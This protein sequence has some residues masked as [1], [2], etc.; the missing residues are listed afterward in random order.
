VT[1]AF[2]AVQLPGAVLDAVVRATSEVW[3]PGRST[4][5]DQWHLTLQFLGDHADV[6]GVIAALDGLDADRGRV[7]IGGAGA[8]PDPRRA[9]VLWLGLAEGADV[10]ARL[11]GAVEA[12]TARLGHARETRPFRPHITLARFAAASDVHGLISEIGDDPI[13]PAWDIDAVSVFESRRDAGGASYI[14]R[15]T[16]PLPG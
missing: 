3:V 12:R 11:A 4:T 5:R 16:I 7:R 1:R 14:E 10:L 2:V 13:G 8:F 9:R 15:A 6:D